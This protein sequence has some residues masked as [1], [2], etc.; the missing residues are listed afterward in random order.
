MDY[1]NQVLG[2]QSSY[3]EDVIIALPNYIYE[4]YRMQRVTLDET[5]VIFVYPKGDLDAV[6]IVKKHIDRIQKAGN[7]PAVLVLMQITYRQ[8]EYLIRE[9][10]PFIVDGKQIYL[11]FMGTY[12]QERCNEDRPQTDTM[13][14]SAQLLLLYYIY[15]GCGELQTNEAV[16]KLH[17][18]STSI[19]RASRQLEAMGLIHNEKRG[20]QKVIFSELKPEAL[21]HKAEAHLR[22]PVK[23]TV[24]VSRSSISQDLLLSGYSALSEY[25]MLN[26]PQVFSFATDSLDLWGKTA[27]KTLQ[28]SEYQCALQLWRYDPKKLTGR[29]TVDELSLALSLRDDKNERIEESI[30][31]MLNQVWREIDD[32]RD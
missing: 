27:S 3:K 30:D 22:N 24:Y 26:P 14:P 12:L 9:H 10:I 15:H 13:L 28:N 6:N 18:T 11:P 25:S 8:K 29:K 5:D 4:R 2:I 20:I 19:S 16:Q 21:F 17:F 7:A 1:L 32:K 23:R 31:E